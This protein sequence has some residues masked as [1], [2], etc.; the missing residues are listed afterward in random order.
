MNFV[1]KVF[2]RF[3]AKL[4]L[5]NNSIQISNSR[6]KLKKLRNIHKGER[7]FI[8]GNGPSLDIK[9]L[10]KLKGEICFGTHRIYEIFD[11][12]E[13]RPNYYCAQDHKLISSSVKSINQIDA[14]NRFIGTVI[15]QRYKGLKGV[16]YVKLDTRKFYPELP[17]FS[18]DISSGVFEGF[19]VSYMCFQIAAHMGF[20][21]IY[22]LGIDHNYSKV[23]LA[24]GTV[25]EDS[26]VQDHFSEKD[27]IEN[28]PQLFKSTLAYEKAKAYGE[29]NG[30]KIFNA[31]R[32][33]K[34]EVF[35][36]VDF[37]LIF[38]NMKKGLE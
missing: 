1:K 29:A 6:K 27:L 15:G 11:K 12:T 13:W 25:L 33:G 7:C 5:L 21:E 3:R 2:I 4:I 17:E 19:T 38:E 18:E 10:E 14:N 32:G 22:L 26:K 31:T 35:E 23:K 9:D 30:I 20:S 36:R 16:T 8:I 37:D 28:L 24:D 34:L